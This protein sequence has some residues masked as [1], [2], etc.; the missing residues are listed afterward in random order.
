MRAADWYF[1]FL[2]PFS[3]LQLVQFDR[4]PPDLEIAYRP[5]LFAGLLGHWCAQR[6]RRPMSGQARAYLPLVPLVRSSARHPLSHATGASVQPTAPAA[7]RH[8]PG[9]GAG[10]QTRDLR[11]HMGRR[12]RPFPR[13]GSVAG[14]DGAPRHRGRRRDHRPALRS[15]RRCGRAPRRPQSAESSACPPLPSEVVELF[16]GFDA[17]DLVLDYLNDPALLATG[18]VRPYFQRLPPSPRRASFSPAPAA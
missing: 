1:D 4:L 12:A 15:R 8:R 10:A 14:A 9:C 3:Y 13:R 5:V 11:R 6:A 17:T 16:W 2:S 7:A 18:A